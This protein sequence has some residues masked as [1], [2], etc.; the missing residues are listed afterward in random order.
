MFA[1]FLGRQKTGNAIG[2]EDAEHID[3]DDTL[4][5]LESEINSNDFFSCC[6]YYTNLMPL[7]FLIANA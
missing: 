4:N 2:V 7:F 3:R 5:H 1:Y 6:F